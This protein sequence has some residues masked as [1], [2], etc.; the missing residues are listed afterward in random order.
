MDYKKKISKKKESTALSYDELQT[1]EKLFK[2]EMDRV[3]LSRIGLAIDKMHA[4]LYLKGI[5]DK[6]KIFSK[7]R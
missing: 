4:I 1:V 5:L 3:S 7:K 2:N 6:I